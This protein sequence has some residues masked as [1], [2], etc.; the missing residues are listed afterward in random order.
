MS[1]A[2]SLHDG[3]PRSIDTNPRFWDISLR[4]ALQLTFGLSEADGLIALMGSDFVSRAFT[5]V[6][7]SSAA[8]ARFSEENRLNP[9]Y[10]TLASDME[11]K[12]PTLFSHFQEL[13]ESFSATDM[14]DTT[15]E[16]FSA[17][18]LRAYRRFQLQ[19]EL[20]AA[21]AEETQDEDL[22]LDR[23]IPFVRRRTILVNFGEIILDWRSFIRNTFDE[24]AV[25]NPD[26]TG[27]LISPLAD[28][29]PG[30]EDYLLSAALVCASFLQEFRHLSI[31]FPVVSTEVDKA[32]QAEYLTEQDR[33]P[34]EA[35]RIMLG[36]KL[37]LFEEMENENRH[38]LAGIAQLVSARDPDERGISAAYLGVYHAYKSLKNQ[39][40]ADYWKRKITEGR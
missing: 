16:T 6:I 1:Y 12:Q 9:R 24:L 33:D 18:A 25:S 36:S 32:S 5:P 7:V 17:S 20:G 28:E 38:L 22:N 13:V 35:G 26:W 39:L 31:P 27:R 34:E 10:Q 4:E 2:E 29:E 40:G 21:D 19:L 23:I 11:I 30:Y 14:P 3:L 15:L 37:A 8:L